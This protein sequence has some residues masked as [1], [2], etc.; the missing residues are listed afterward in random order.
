MKTLAWRK[1]GPNGP[2]AVNYVYI[3]LQFKPEDM[4]IGAY[5]RNDNEFGKVQWSIW[6]CLVPMLPIFIRRVRYL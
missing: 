1:F 2:Y 4:W 6:I 3:A 5:W